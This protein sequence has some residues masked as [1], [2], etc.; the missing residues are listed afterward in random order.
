ML[1]EAALDPKPVARQKT[2][3]CP[4]LI[5]AATWRQCALRR[6]SNGGRICEPGGIRSGRV[7]ATYP[8]R[9]PI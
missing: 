4:K 7:R 6:R 8:W 1:E 3:E 9:R 2:R 5:E